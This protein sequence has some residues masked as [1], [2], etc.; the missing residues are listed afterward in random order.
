MGSGEMPH[1]SADSDVDTE[2]LASDRM[3][4]R[5][6]PSKHHLPT[7]AP[8]PEP[9]KPSELAGKLI[10]SQEYLD[11]DVTWAML[12][13]ESGAAEQSKGSL[14]PAIDRPQNPEPW[15]PSQAAR[16]PP[17]VGDEAKATLALLDDE[18]SRLS[19]EDA[20]AATAI[21]D[22]AQEQL[23]NEVVSLARQ[24][25]EEEFHQ[26][27]HVLGCERALAIAKAVAA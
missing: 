20:A 22:A 7:R 9:W 14:M 17:G 2:L 19:T 10:E 16:L 1:M 18:H 3:A 27:R 11:D 6:A 26:R 25:Q 21:A 23:H 12:K 8:N 5:E 4:S 24:A 15:L 13:A